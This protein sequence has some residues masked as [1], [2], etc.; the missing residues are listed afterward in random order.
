MTYQSVNPYD[1]KILK[2]FEHLSSAQ[3][4]QSLATADSCF[5]AWKHTSYADRA[6][7]LHKAAKLMRDHVD[8]FARLATLEMGK[9]IGEARGEVQFSADILAYYAKH[10]E[11]F[12]AP[13]KLEPKVGD[14]HM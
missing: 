2:S 9:R 6:A 8:D 5:Q 7:V 11:A 12:L 4:E 1:G 3:L 14:A 13:T 10:A